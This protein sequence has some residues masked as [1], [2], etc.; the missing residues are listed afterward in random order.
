MGEVVV[1]CD[2]LAEAD[3]VEAATLLEAKPGIE[4]S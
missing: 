3:V 1:Y 4:P 2:G